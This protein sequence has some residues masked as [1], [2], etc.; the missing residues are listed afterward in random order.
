LQLN[1][2]LNGLDNADIGERITK[3]FKENGKVFRFWM[4]DTAQIMVADRD[5]AKVAK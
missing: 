5:V 1:P 2:H 4:F 3:V